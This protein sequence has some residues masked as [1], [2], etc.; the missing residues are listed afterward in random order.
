MASKLRRKTLPF[1]RNVRTSFKIGMISL[2]DVESVLS[3]YF[4]YIKLDIY[5]PE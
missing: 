2:N 3:R 4:S 1:K 5:S